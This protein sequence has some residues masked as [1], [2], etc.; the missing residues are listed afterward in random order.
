LDLEGSNDLRVS[1]NWATDVAGGARFGYDL[2]V[3]VL[4]ASVAAMLLQFL[5]LKLGVATGRDLAQACRDSFHPRLVIALWLIVEIA[6]IATDMAELLGAAIALYCLIG[7]PLPAGVVIMGLDVMVLLVLQQKRLRILESVVMALTL[8]I[9]VSLTYIV[10][11]ASPNWG[12]VFYGFVPKGELFTNSKQLFLAI[13]IL[14][15]TVMPHNLFLHS[16]LVQSRQYPRTLSGKQYAVKYATI[17]SMLSL[18]LAFVVNAFILIIA[19]AAFH[20][21]YQDTEDI[22]QAFDRLTIVLR[23]RAASIMFGIAL[24]ASGQQASLTGTLAGQIVMEGMLDMK[25]SPW[26]RR[27]ITRLIAIAP[28]VVITIALGEAS[29]VLLV[30]S[31][32]TISLTLSFVTFP[33]LYL[34][35]SERK[36]GKSFVNS[37]CTNFAGAVVVLVI[38][39]MNMYLIASPSTWVFS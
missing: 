4:C 6:M 31:Q 36:M 22:F 23:T 3:A 24:L 35:S 8:I 37:R 16:S 14:G 32:V 9:I 29:I 30:I 28:T 18:C 15:A 17:D 1:G 13:G 10:A 34:T 19:A 26:K 2:L 21:A 12:D 33:L 20:D 27:F 39:G 7:L 5:S 25:V 11:L 38:A